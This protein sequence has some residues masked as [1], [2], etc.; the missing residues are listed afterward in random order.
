MKW[1]FFQ[2]YKTKIRNS[3]FSRMLEF[4]L[5]LQGGGGVAAHARG[6]HK[7]R[8]RQRVV[9]LAPG[10]VDGQRRH[11]QAAAVSWT[12][13]A[14]RQPHRELS[15]T[16]TFHTLITNWK[17]NWSHWGELF[18]GIPLYLTAL[19]TCNNTNHLIMWSSQCFSSSSFKPFD[20]RR[21]VVDI[22]FN[23]T[24]L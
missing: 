4:V 20:I 9:A 15:S 12:I 18:D 1:T 19:F 14:E 17:K 6:F 13:R 8:G 3:S 21:R 16:T 5:L 24:L 7:H 11:R 10:G 22:Y 23:Y 2:F